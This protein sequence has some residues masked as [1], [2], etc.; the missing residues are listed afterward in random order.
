MRRRT[1]ANKQIICITDGEPTAHLEAGELVLAYPPTERT[2][3]ATLEEVRACVRAGIQVSTFA[4]IEDYFAL[5]L[6]DFVDQMARTARG[7]AVY[8]K[9]GELGSYALNSFVRG[10]RSRRLLG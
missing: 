6:V 7:R 8:C 9:A 3:R 10:R 1:S 2:A 4:L 5:G